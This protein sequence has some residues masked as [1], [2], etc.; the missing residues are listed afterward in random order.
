[1]PDICKIILKYK[2]V[3]QSNDHVTTIGESAT[4]WAAVKINTHKTPIVVTM[5]KER[6]WTAIQDSSWI[7]ANSHLIDC[8][9]KAMFTASDDSA[10]SE[11]QC[12]DQA[13]SDAAKA[14]WT[15]L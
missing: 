4:N 9:D 14:T 8:G 5:N 7:R 15:S 2:A 6:D 3:F 10:A 1:M 13:D 12:Q 11:S